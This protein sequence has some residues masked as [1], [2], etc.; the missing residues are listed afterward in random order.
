[1][2]P[3][4]P[5][6][7]KN[8]FKVLSLVVAIVLAAASPS[9]RAQDL[10]PTERVLVPIFFAGTLAGGYG[11]VW[12]S[13]LVVTNR[14]E[15]AIGLAGIYTTC[16][17]DPCVVTPGVLP[18]LQAEGTIVPR[19]ADQQRVPARNDHLAVLRVAGVRVAGHR[20]PAKCRR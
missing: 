7:L 18:R 8:Q 6:A 9:A 10:P 2:N 19:P 12:K 3:E 5:R 15:T 17:F 1:M 20:R 14:S 11:S 16:H 4:L 13:E